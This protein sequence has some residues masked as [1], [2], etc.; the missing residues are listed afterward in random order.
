[1]NQPKDYEDNSHIRFGE[2]LVVGFCCSI[3]LVV[4]GWALWEWLK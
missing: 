3:A 4:I 2:G 1:M